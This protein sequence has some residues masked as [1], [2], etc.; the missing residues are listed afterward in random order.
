MIVSITPPRA[1]C[2]K[3]EEEKRKSF[4]QPDAVRGER[5]Q[6]NIWCRVSLLENL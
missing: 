3:R 4:E 1:E 6:A 5:Q 2:V